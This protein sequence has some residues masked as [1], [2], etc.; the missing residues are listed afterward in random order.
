MK[1]ILLI[2]LAVASVFVMTAC[3]NTASS[4]YVQSYFLEDSRTMGVSDV[5]ETLEYNVA[6]TQSE[7]ASPLKI[8]IDSEKSSYK[9]VLKN[10]TYAEKSC[11]LLTSELKIVGEMKN[12]E[13]VTQLNDSIVTECYFLGLDNNLRPLFSKR[14]VKANSPSLKAGT[15]NE[16]EINYYEY[17]YQIKYTDWN[18]KSTFKLGENNKGEFDIKDGDVTE[19]QNIT[20]K[21]YYIDNELL[22][23]APRAMKLDSVSASF[24]TIDPLSKVN[25]KMKITNDT[26]AVESISKDNI[27][28][29]NSKV[30]SEATVNNTVLSIDS[31][32]SGNTIK[33]TYISNQN[34]QA[35]CAMLTLTQKAFYALGEF[36]YNL[37]I[38]NNKLN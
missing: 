29:L 5:N 7:T 35:R 27:F 6:F 17:E 16:Y 8:T 13:T 12:G 31:S 15:E 25:R 38:A 23:F 14:T 20:N 32:Y 11:Y 28:Y 3:N 37:K 21:S 33:A 4:I 18:A 34:L 30:I 24:Y 10:T 36:T 26:T 9:T 19:Y 22:F 2:I 1:K